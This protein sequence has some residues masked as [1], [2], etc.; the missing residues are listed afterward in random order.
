MTPAIHQPAVSVLLPIYNGE[1]FLA[2]AID[3]LLAQS[4]TDFELLIV[5]DGSSD[6][7][8]D[9]VERYDDPRIVLLNRTHAGLVVALNEGIR[10][11]R[12]R[13][14]ARMDHDDLSKP[15]RLALQVAFL[16]ANPE[17]VLVGTAFEVIDRD[18]AFLSVQKTLTRDQDIRRRAFYANPFAHGSVMMRRQSLLAI[19]GYRDEFP[20]V[21]DYDLWVRIMS[22]HQ[23]ANLPRVLYSYRK[24][25]GVSCRNQE[26]Q[27][28]G[29]QRL[30]ETIWH[31]LPLQP[32]S[33]REAAAGA[34][35]YR[36][37]E[38]ETGFRL[39]D[40]FLRDQLVLSAMLAKRG[41]VLAALINCLATLTVAP[42]KA[43]GSMMR[44]VR[45][46]LRRARR[47]LERVVTRP[48][49]RASAVHHAD[50]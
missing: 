38:D 49:P 21:E 31:H 34:R 7:S 37:I 26:Q 35:H 33:R 9:I 42:A 30:Q 43:L 41:C 4:M 36:A 16:D 46:L 48:R 12:G 18:G 23:V 6:T 40:E 47:T 27:A 19:G 15:E 10:R 5:N 8:K 32:L 39:L 13:Y 28:L 25:S 17:V 45:S 14:V 22:R 11:C 44:M 50:S 1:E 3:S 2:G 20:F 24:N 29:C